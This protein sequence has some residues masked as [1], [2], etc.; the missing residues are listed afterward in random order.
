VRAIIAPLAARLDEIASQNHRRIV[1][2]GDQVALASRLYAQ[3][4]NTGVLLAN[5]RPSTRRAKISVADS[6]WGLA[7]IAGA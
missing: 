5:G 2:E 3:Q 4:A 7:G 6:M 1:Y